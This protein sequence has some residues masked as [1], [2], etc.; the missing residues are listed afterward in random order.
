M[1]GGCAAQ[2]LSSAT[3]CRVA[4]ST[5]VEAD[6]FGQQ[7]VPSPQA[8]VGWIMPRRHVQSIKVVKSRRTTRG[9]LSVGLD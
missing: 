1:K 6:P 4:C 3:A 7:S 5:Y 2:Q 9:T 8:S